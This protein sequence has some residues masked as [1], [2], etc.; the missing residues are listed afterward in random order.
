MTDISHFS[1]DQK[2]AWDLLQTEGNVFVTGEAG[3]GKSF[4]I[5]EF[6]R[7]KDP[8]KFPILA[9]TGAAAVL[10]GGR[11]FH[12]YLGLGIMEGGKD[13]TVGRAL[14]DR[15]LVLRL[16]KTE[17]LLFDEVSML[18]GETLDAAETICR[19]AR[20]S[21]EP[22]GGLRVVAVGDF[23]QL[24]PVHNGY[25]PKG[26]AFLHPV[27]RRSQFQSVVLKQNMRSADSD[28]LS[29]LN[30]I[31]AG[32]MTEDVERF[33]N[34]RKMDGDDVFEGTR[35]FARRNQT[36][37]FNNNELDKLDTQMFCF[38]TVYGGQERF[39]TQLRKNSPLGE[40]LFIKVGALV[41][42]RQ[43]DPKQRWV[44]GSTGYVRDINP[45]EITIELLS[46]RTVK[47]EKVTYS[48][49][50]AE[51]V[52]VAHATNFPLSLAYAATIHK[53]QG[54]TLDRVMVNLSNLW[55]P[56]Q[57]YVAVSRAVDPKGLRVEAWSPNSI[58]ADP[59]VQR[60][61]ESLV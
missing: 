47:V 56:G 41:M 30:K 9:S 2:H 26:W 22:W 23:A 5:R 17:G 33:L 12:S 50:N 10:I 19:F 60:F 25:G 55:E 34:Q 20:E 1:E 43:N 29:V 31:R 52:P 49:L 8:K 27:W 38:P 24:P 44:N 46:G 53:A 11:T 14:Q 3:S 40:E 58:K 28:F 36:D 15:K 32:A 51:G 42:L 45:S 16:K 48:M 21:V 7:G 54:M 61:Y 35:L 18:S 37:A 6:M 57:A 13:A 39:V 59:L 4:L